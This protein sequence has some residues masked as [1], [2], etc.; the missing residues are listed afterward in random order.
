MQRRPTTSSYTF[1]PLG[2]PPPASSSSSV[3]ICSAAHVRGGVIIGPRIVGPARP[4]PRPAPSSPSQ[5][6]TSDHEVSGALATVLG[7]RVIGGP[8]CRGLLLSH[9]LGGGGGRGLTPAP[10][11]YDPN[12]HVLAPLT[13]LPLIHS[14]PT[15]PTLHSL[16]HLPPPPRSRQHLRRRPPPGRCGH[17]TVRDAPHEIL[18]LVAL[19]H[20]RVGLQLSRTLLIH[21]EEGQG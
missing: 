12:T 9:G 15:H 17:V 2:Q 5:G 1:S 7:G 21:P 8:H 11:K 3:R 16:V 6:W 19:H 10:T 20:L 13:A 4:R 18:G 14:L